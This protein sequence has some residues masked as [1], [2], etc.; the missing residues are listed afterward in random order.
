M[1]DVDEI[2]DESDDAG[3]QRQADLQYRTQ[4]AMQLNNLNRASSNN[5]NGLENDNRT[6]RQRMWRRK[7]QPFQCLINVISCWKK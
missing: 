7:K 5:L 4:K 1:D 6:A 3:F 2:G